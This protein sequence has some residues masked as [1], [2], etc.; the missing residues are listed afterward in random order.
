MLENLKKIAFNLYPKGISQDSNYYKNSK[1]YN[2]LLNAL[3]KKNTLSSTWEI[4]KSNLKFEILSTNFQLHDIDE[5]NKYDRCFKVILYNNS[6]KIS[7]GICISIAIEFFSVYEVK[8]N[9]ENETS[10]SAIKIDNCFEIQRLILK[11]I[12]KYFPYHQE[13][14]LDLIL[15]PLDDIV[16]GNNGI[17][18]HENT[19]KILKKMTFFNAFFCDNYIW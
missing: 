18:L 10:V 5:I 11:E 15:F 6:E 16:F 9:N 13:F 4:F 12:K 1:E 3:E 19:S 7:Y 2:N 17:L 14:P 8:Y